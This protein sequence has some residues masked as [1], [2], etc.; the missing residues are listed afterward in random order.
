MGLVLDRHGL[1]LPTRQLSAAQRT[2]AKL[3]DQLWQD[4][5]DQFF[6]RLEL[7]SGARVLVY[8]CG[9]GHDL[10][11]LARLV[12]PLGEVV[13]V[14]PDPFL[15]HE[16]RLELKE[17]R[18]LGIRVVL[19]DPAHDPIPDGLYEVIF[20]AWRM[21]EI[22]P[23]PLQGVRSLLARLRP[24][25]APQG[26]LAIWEDCTTGM[27]LHPPLPLLQRILRLWQRERPDTSLACSLAGEFAF[28]NLMF[29]SAR[30]VQKAEVPGSATGRWW[31]HWLHQEGPARLSPRQWQRLQQQWESRRIDPNTLYFSPQA[32]GVVGRALSA[33][34][35]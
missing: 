21:N 28:C 24:W 20:V 11:R 2:Q 26:R 16:A 31:D 7:R 23:L 5:L 35:A 33:Y 13:G 15:A 1:I 19:G 10:P 22:Q 29:E 18:G 4:E 25:L 17:H 6:E 34:V 9:L 12:A 3:L 30:P 32:F 27:R 8:N 14:Q